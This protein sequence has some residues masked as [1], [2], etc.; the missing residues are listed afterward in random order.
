LRIPP[1][2]SETQYGKYKI[3]VAGQEQI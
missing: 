2:T 1:D 3:L